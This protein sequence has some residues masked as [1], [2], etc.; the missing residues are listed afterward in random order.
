MMRRFPVW[1]VVLN[2]REAA[3]TLR[4]LGA[5][6]KVRYRPLGLWSWTTTRGRGRWPGCARSGPRWSRGAT[7]ATPGRRG[8]RLALDAGAEAVWIVNPDAYVERGSLR[9][10][11]RVLRR[12]GGRH[13]RA[14]HP[15]GGERHPEDPVRRRA[16]R[17]GSRRPQG[18]DRPGHGTGHAAGRCAFVD[19]VPG[20]TMLVRRKVF[21]DAGLLPEEWFLYFEETDFCVRAAKAGVEGGGG[22]RLPGGAPLSSPDG[23]PAETLIYYFVRNRVPVRD[24]AHRGA[25]RSPARRPR[26]VRP[27]RRRR[28]QER[29][30]DGWGG[31]RSWWRWPWRTPRRGDGQEGRHQAN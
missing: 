15:G 18:L 17:L 29:K 26:R 4:C 13:R 14:S 3:D 6:G 20:A 21:E 8:I 19:F 28:V 25:L 5:L 2:H 24:A 12:G 10:L 9:R 23:L 1:A 22:D 11:V 16:H 31:S 7:W 27:R 30:P